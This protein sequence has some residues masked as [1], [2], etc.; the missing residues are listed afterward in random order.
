M[1]TLKME[2]GKAEAYTTQKLRIRDELYN[3]NYPLPMQS[4]NEYLIQGLPEEWES[5]RSSLRRQ[6]RTLKEGLMINY[7]RD[8]DALQQRKA[9]AEVAYTANAHACEGH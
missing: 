7:I 6:T 1:Q 4:F 8:E 9:R 2:P 5:F 3:L